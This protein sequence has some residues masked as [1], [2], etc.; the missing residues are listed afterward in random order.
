MHTSQRYFTKV[1][2]KIQRQQHTVKPKY[3][4][5]KQKL[6]RFN[7][8]YVDFRKN[9]RLLS[10]YIRVHSGDAML[11]SHPER[12]KRQTNHAQLFTAS[13]I[14]SALYLLLQ[15]PTPCYFVSLLLLQLHSCVFT[16]DHARD[17]ASN[18]PVYIAVY[19]AARLYNCITT[20]Y[21]LLL[22]GQNAKLP[23]SKAISKHC[24]QSKLPTSK[25]G[26]LQGGGWFKAY[27]TGISTGRKLWTI[28][29]INVSR[30][31][32]NIRQISQR[33]P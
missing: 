33:W 4:T 5:Q 18:G 14:S 21:H 29:P 11:Q 3:P 23:N 10:L 13:P 26:Y 31:M 32:S 2:R 16:G 6:I 15:L 12:G 28:A 9:Q 8:G 19:K 20:T 30:S 24:Q 22:K 27:A 25:A 7:G 17:H 1:M